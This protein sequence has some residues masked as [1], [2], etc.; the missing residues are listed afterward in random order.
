[1]R[2]GL[3]GRFHSRGPTWSALRDS[4]GFQWVLDPSH[5]RIGGPSAGP[6]RGRRARGQREGAAEAGRGRVTRGA[7]QWGARPR[8]SLLRAFA[9]PAASRERPESWESGERRAPSSAAGSAG[10]GQERWTRGRVRSRAARA[11]PRQATPSPGG[12]RAMYRGRV[13]PPWGITGR[14]LARAVRT[15]RGGPGNAGTPEMRGP[16]ERAGPTKGKSGCAG[17]IR[18]AQLLPAEATRVRGTPGP[19]FP[20][21]GAWRPRGGE[22]TVGHCSGGLRGDAKGVTGRRVRYSPKLCSR[23]RATSFPRTSHSRVGTHARA[24]GGH[25]HGCTAPSTRSHTTQ[26]HTHL[27]VPA[28]CAYVLFPHAESSGPFEQTLPEGPLR[29][30]AAGGR[31]PLLETVSPRG[32]RGCLLPRYE[33]VKSQIFD[34]SP[35]AIAPDRPWGAPAA[36]QVREWQ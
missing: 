30:A 20:Y 33:K 7:S 4:A 32:H 35:S 34:L 28:A 23:V 3:R 15:T 17:Q 21:G 13:G 19:A 16:R 26:T 29:V 9:A 2:W 27:R 5:V 10:C 1:M 36:L 11:R 6:R 14:P 31:S 22:V 25:P 24:P 18:C 12:R 8:P